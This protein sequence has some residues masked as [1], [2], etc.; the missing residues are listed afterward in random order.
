M[1]ASKM[2]SGSPLTFVSISGPTLDRASAKAMRAHTTRANFAR[3]R[4]RL[5]LEYTGGKKKPA[6]AGPLQ[7]EKHGLD[8]ER[9]LALHFGFP[10]SGHPGL[11]QRLNRKDAFFINNCE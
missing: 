11:D 7:V 10:V 1:P 6:H 3:R 2:D 9:G 8:T 5:V 4:R